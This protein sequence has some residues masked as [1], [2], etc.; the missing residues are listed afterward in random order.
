MVMTCCDSRLT[1][2]PLGSFGFIQRHNEV[3]WMSDGIQMVPRPR[4]AVS[5]NEVMGLV[6]HMM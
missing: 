2:S 6:E 5:K 4:Q 3:N 1:V